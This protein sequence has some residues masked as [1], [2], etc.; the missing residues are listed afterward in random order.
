[1]LKVINLKITVYYA[2]FALVSVVIITPITRH[3]LSFMLGFNVLLAYIPM[4]LIW[5]IM[6]LQK[7]VNYTRI[8]TGSIILFI[9]FVLFYPNTFY[10]ITDLIHI[11]QTDFYQYVPTETYS[12]FIETT[13]MKDIIPFITIFQIAFAMILG[14]FAGVYSLYQF[15]ELMMKQ[16]IKHLVREL[17]IISI[18]FLSSIGIY[19]GRFLR[20][21][22]W[23][24]LN[25]INILKEL[26]YD[27]S[28]FMLYFIVIFTLMQV[29]L[30][31]TCRSLFQKFSEK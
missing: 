26:Y 16:N 15:N 6:K 2:V 19:I 1:M 9:I 8:R 17:T 10:I 7:D 23:E 4:F 14:I 25:P 20:F 5:Y 21:F 22:S 12:F 27:A 18:L 11:D 13:Y 31:Y 3:F 29:I 28:L 24:I 30:Y